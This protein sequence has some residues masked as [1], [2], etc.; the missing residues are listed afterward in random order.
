MPEKE[1]KD[2]IDFVSAVIDEKEGLGGLSWEDLDAET[3]ADL[4]KRAEESGTS[5]SFLQDVMKNAKNRIVFD[6]SIK[7]RVRGVA[8]ERERRLRGEPEE[9]PLTF[10]EFLS[11]AQEE[12]GQTFTSEVREE[13]RKIY[14]EEVARLKTE[15]KAPKFSSTELKKLE[16]AELLNVSRQEQL[17]FLFAGEGGGDIDFDSL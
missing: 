6:R 2:S 17:D 9:E 14:E 16:Q 8:E 7:E 1:E 12:A 4:I 10:E 13:F 11:E 15:A 3:Q 5:L